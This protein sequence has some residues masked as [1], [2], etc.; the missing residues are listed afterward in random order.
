M[1]EAFGHNRKPKL[2][3]VAP[4]PPPLGGARVSAKLFVDYVES[5]GDVH[6]VHYDLPVRALE[7]DKDSRTK[8]LRTALKTLQILC[9]LP[10]AR[11]TVIFCSRNFGVS[12]GP[13]LICIAKLFRRPVYLRF[14]GG[15]PM[16]SKYLKIP[17]VGCVLLWLLRGAEKIIVETRQGASEFPP[18][19]RSNIEVIPGYRPPTPPDVGDKRRPKAC[20]SFV[21]VGAVNEAKGVLDLLNA[22]ANMRDQATDIPPV[23]LHI[24]GTG[25]QTV[26]EKLASAPK[27]VWHGAV[28]NDDLRRQLPAHDVFVFPSRYDTEGHP[29]VVV[30][31]MM[32]PLA[33]IAS[34]SSDSISD[35]ITDGEEG[36]LIPAA[37]VSSLRDAMI[38]LARNPAKRDEL[39]AKA[40]IKSRQFDS[41]HVLPLL[42]AAFGLSVTARET[43]S[44]KELDAVPGYDAP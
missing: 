41:R 32:A 1:S 13:P 21:Y 44:S 39:A 14:F 5:K 20:V 4:V 11:N 23:E 40:L 35:L 34:C 31:A 26:T 37:D 12:I 30:E 29:G 2:L 25:D 24:Y 10:F 15:R 27:V 3:L 33:I 7:Q 28:P 22:F 36:I 9:E 17:F 8:I 16:Q 43:D 38:C 18:H 42:S 19:L 6:V